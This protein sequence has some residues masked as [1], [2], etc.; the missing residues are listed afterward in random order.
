[1]L[2]SSF[3]SVLGLLLKPPKNSTGICG[4]K[5]VFFSP[6]ELNSK[7]NEQTLHSAE[8]IGEVQENNNGQVR[9]ITSIY[10][11]SKFHN[12]YTKWS[13]VLGQDAEGA[14]LPNIL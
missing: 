14:E 2:L 5:I 8:I 4:L 7:Q 13:R 3:S 6:E 10:S 11:A 1:M 12:E 9:S